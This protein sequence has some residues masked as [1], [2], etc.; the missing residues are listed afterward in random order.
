[1]K[2]LWKLGI[3][4]VVLLALVGAAVGIVAAQTDETPTPSAT[5]EDE[6]TATPA[7]EQEDATETPSTEEGDGGSGQEALRDQFLDDLAERLGISRDQLD[8]A[9]SESALA[10][11]DQAVADGRITEEEATRIRERIE[12]GE[13]PVFFGHHGYR[14][15]GGCGLLGVNP[16]ELADFLGITAN[17]LRDARQNEQSLAQIAEANGKSRDELRTFML[18]EIEEYVNQAVE[19]GRITQ[20]RADE[21]LSRASE[22]IDEIIDRE[23]LPPRPFKFGPEEGSEEGTEG[24][25]L[26]I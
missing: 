9:L 7:A 2:Q 25:S 5:A 13:F 1:M 26:T 15:G 19:N 21:L 17:E 10:L 14:H 20:E 12:A 24:A 18:S 22:R 6:A 23:G 11:V 4:A 8:Q 16:E 3:V